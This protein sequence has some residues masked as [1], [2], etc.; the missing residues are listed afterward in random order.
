MVG[1]VGFT[2]PWWLSV[3]LSPAREDVPLTTIVLLALSLAVVLAVCWATR[4]STA[5]WGD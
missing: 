1:A 4:W 3:A 5:R 2:V